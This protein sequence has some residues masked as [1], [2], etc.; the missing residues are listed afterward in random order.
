VCL[1]P[2]LTDNKLAHYNCGGDPVQSRIRKAET[3]Y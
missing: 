1:P 3:S 2:A